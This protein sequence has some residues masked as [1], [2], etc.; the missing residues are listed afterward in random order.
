MWSIDKNASPVIEYHPGYK[1]DGT[2]AFP[3]SAAFQP[4]MWFQTHTWDGD[5][6]VTAPDDFIAWADRVLRWVRPNW[7]LIDNF[8]HFSP[9]AAEAW[10]RM[11]QVVL[12]E[13]WLGPGAEQISH[14]RR[15]QDPENLIT[16][17]DFRAVV[18]K[19]RKDQAKRLIISIRRLPTLAP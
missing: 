14:W 18:T 16:A 10:R 3:R 8:Y 11:W 19:A 15:A 7:A 5:S 6:P 9:S 12:D 2:P 4:R 17:D 1:R 13:P